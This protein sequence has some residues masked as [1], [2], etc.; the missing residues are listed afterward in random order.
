MPL[1][2][3]VRLPLMPSTISWIRISY[4]VIILSCLVLVEIKKRLDVRSEHQ[5]VDFFIY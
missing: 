3:Y 5:G 4:I 2:R 1:P